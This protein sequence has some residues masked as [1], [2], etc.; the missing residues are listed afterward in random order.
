M[1]QEP[2]MYLYGFAKEN[3]LASGSYSLLCVPLGH[4]QH[5]W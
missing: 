2:Q 3:E 4:W 5:S 1:V